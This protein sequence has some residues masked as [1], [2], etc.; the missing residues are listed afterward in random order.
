MIF[1][2]LTK[3]A[4]GGGSEPLAPSRRRVQKYLFHKII[5]LFHKNNDIYIFN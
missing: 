5:F 1:I 3:Y 2:F 4:V